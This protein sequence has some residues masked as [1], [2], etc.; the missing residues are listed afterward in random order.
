M[1]FIPESIFHVLPYDLRGKTSSRLEKENEKIK[2]TAMFFTVSLF[3]IDRDSAVIHT[4]IIS[5]DS[6]KVRGITRSIMAG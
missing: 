6:A 1:G 4:A 5:T 3:G 2:E